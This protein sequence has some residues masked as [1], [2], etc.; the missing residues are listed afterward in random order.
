MVED[1]NP[2]RSPQAALSDPVTEDGELASREGRLGAAILDTI[3]ALVITLPIM[4]FG[5]YF[6]Q[7]ETNSEAG[8]MF[9]PIGVLALW[10]AIGFALF[11]LI[12]A[13][14]LH[15]SGQTWGKRV[16]KIKIV[17]MNG[18]QP[19][20]GHLLL[21][22]Y[23]PINVI[24]IVPVLGNVFGIVDVLMIFRADRRCAHDWIADTRVVRAH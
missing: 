1:E 20:L 11:V 9:M 16:C 3:I 8:Q 21:R 10:G 14:P 4:Y 24:S 17:R 6:D 13:Y 15:A 22:R 5:G 2:Y 19:S 7:I 18:A 12:Q 23:L